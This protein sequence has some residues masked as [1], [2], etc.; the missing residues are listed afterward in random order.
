MKRCVLHHAKVL[1]DV[2]RTLLNM[3]A[4]WLARPEMTHGLVLETELWCRLA[5]APELGLKVDKPKFG[6]TAVHMKWVS[7]IV[8]AARLMKAV[9][10]CEV[11]PVPGMP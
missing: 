6:S 11:D 9:I 2:R 7:A 3:G 1:A 10:R 4:S 8:N 5:L